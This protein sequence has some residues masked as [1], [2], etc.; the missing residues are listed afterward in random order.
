MFNFEF[1][2]RNKNQIIENLK[3]EISAINQDKRDLEDEI[4]LSREI[5]VDEWKNFQH[6]VQAL[7][8]EG[9]Q[10]LTYNIRYYF[11][12]SYQHKNI[13]FFYVSFSFIWLNYL[14]KI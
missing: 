8:F 9:E 1:E 10:F 3:N 13:A 7:A 4:S 12:S 2:L 5:W 14:I 6:K 11:L